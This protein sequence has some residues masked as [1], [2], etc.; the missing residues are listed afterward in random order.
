MLKKVWGLLLCLSIFWS[1]GATTFANCT[2]ESEPSFTFSVDAASY[3]GGDLVRLTIH[4]ETTLED[5]AGF[6]VSIAYDDTRLS[7]LRVEPS[8]QIKNK[9]LQTDGT[10]NPVRSTYVCNVDLGHAPALSG[11]ILTYVFEVNDGASAGSTELD[12]TVDQICN[13]QGEQLNIACSESVA[14]EVLPP[15]SD[16]AFLKSLIPSSGKLSPTFSPDTFYYT[17]DVPYRVSSVTFETLAGENGTVS[18]NRKTLQK[19]GSTTSITITVTAE[20]RKQKAQYVVEVNRAEEPE[21]PEWEAYLTELI[22]SVGEL[23]P[24]FSPDITEYIVN[25]DAEVQ[26]LTFQADAGEEG[27]VSISREK[28]NR[29]GTSTEIKITVVSVDKKNRQVYTV[30]VNRAEEIDF[31]EEV[32]F[33]TA[34]Q[35]SVGNLEP[36]FSPDILD[37]TLQ[38]D[39]EVSSVTFQANATEGATISVNRKTLYKAGS[40]TEIVVTVRSSDRKETKRYIVSVLRGE[41][42]RTTTTKVGTDVTD[43][44]HSSKNKSASSS[45]K[46]AMLHSDGA[47]EAYIPKKVGEEE[48]SSGFI[49]PTAVSEAMV[50]EHRNSIYRENSQFLTFL[51]GMGAAVLCILLGM[52]LVLLFEKGKTKKS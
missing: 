16:Q 48:A 45:L 28:L 8:D 44:S 6:C 27:A 4:A 3:G 24:A 31:S 51:A 5:L 33:L 39:A 35:P 49:E 9:T 37:Y 46:N 18:V 47:E 1:L 50:E 21:D 52:G 7:F 15:K 40:T 22:P 29:A 23:Q 42:Q 12:V 41:E 25:V 38:V 43:Q 30:T 11:T 19:A 14:I 36:P 17:L 32:F 2:T 13:W 20:D 26:Y 10:N 34:L